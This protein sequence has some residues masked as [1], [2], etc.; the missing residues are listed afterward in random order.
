[1]VAAA[2][3]AVAAIGPP[4]FARLGFQ[5]P[6]LL[7]ALFFVAGG[8]PLLGKFRRPRDGLIRKLLKLKR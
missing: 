5:Q 6:E 3:G 1:M 7:A 8:A 4:L 2:R